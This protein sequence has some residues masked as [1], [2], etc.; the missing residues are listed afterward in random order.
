MQHNSANMRG[1]ATPC[2]SLGMNTFCIGYTQGDEKF[3]E[4]RAVHLGRFVKPSK[5]ERATWDG[6]YLTGVISVAVPDR[7]FFSEDYENTRVFH[8]AV[9]EV[10][11]RK[12]I[13]THQA[14]LN[15]HP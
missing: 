10:P 11:R 2:L 14:D 5:R 9:L 7:C 6:M 8:S 15:P 1:A 12:Y 4:N 13:S 3:Q